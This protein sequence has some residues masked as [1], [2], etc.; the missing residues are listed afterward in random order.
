MKDARQYKSIFKATSLIGGVQIFQVLTN[1]VRGKMIA[2]LL[3]AAGMGINSLFIS[4]ISM[5]TN[6]TGLGLNFSAVREIAKANESDNSLFLAEVITIFKRWL[7][8]SAILALFV[9]IFLSPILSRYTF[10]SEE[11]T[12]AFMFLALMAFFNILS[13]GN[14][15]ILQG[16]RSLKKYALFNLF[17]SISSLVISFP[18][19]YF[20]GV[21]GIIPALIV[22]SLITLFVSLIYV[23]SLNI[24]RKNV[25]IKEIYFRGSSMVKLG[26]TMMLSTTIGSIIHYLIN[27]S[28]SSS[29]IADL[30]LYQAGMSITSQS[31]GLVFTA[32]AVDYYPRLSAVSADNSRVREMTNQQGVITLLIAT[33]VLTILSLMSPLIVI[34]LLSKDFLVIVDFIRLIAFGILFKASSYSIGAISFSKGD[35]KVFFIV[36]GVLMNIATLIFTAGGYKVG[37]LIGIGIGYILLHITYLLFIIFITNRLYEFTISKLYLKI[38][39]VSFVVLGFITLLL[40]IEIFNNQISYIISSCLALLYFWFSFKT[41]TKIMNLK[42]MLN[43]LLRRG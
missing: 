19:Y 8:A 17:S 10:D 31:I 20:M 4:T 5:I 14:A 25:G 37:G 33:P 30:G 13:S 3:G 29:S 26:V 32:M 11:Y 2:L 36:E 39:G 24:K 28:I 18:F 27:I 41:L 38:I 7:M 35:K 34:L 16:V 23:R 42:D 15:S 12:F 22:T 43:K 9:V 6:F 21:K 1:L 40:S